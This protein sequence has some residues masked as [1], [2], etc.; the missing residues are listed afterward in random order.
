M[1]DCFMPG[2]SSIPNPDAVRAYLR[3]LRIGRRLSYTKFAK[4]IGLSRRA[5]IGWEMGE[6]EELKQ[7][8]LIRAV[9]ALGASWKH[10]ARLIEPDAGA[11]T[12]RALARER[13]AEIAAS[14]TDDE[15]KKTLLSIRQ[16]RGV[17]ASDVLDDDSAPL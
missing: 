13:L 11:D 16:K 17:D 1:A 9:D 8:P 12:G 3:D 7:G 4:M 5:L 15:L 2:D 6:T 10:L 14:M